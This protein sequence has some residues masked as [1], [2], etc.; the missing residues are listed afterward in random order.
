MIYDTISIYKLLIPST[1]LVYATQSF[2]SVPWRISSVK[3]YNT[4]QPRLD[5]SV[6]YSTSTTPC[7]Y[8]CISS[9]GEY[10]YIDHAV[11]LDC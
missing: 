7:S 8:E 6:S 2:I 11:C 5:I 1:L 4:S 9:T 10:Q 3:Y